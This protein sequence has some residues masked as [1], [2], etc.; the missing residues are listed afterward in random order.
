MLSILLESL[1]WLGFGIIVVAYGLSSASIIKN[2][3]VLYQVLNLVGALFLSIISFY[4]HA[5]QPA[6]LNVVWFFVALSSLIMILKK[7]KVLK[8]Q[9]ALLQRE[10]L[11]R[12]TVS[13]N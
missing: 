10:E 1:G 11:L 4:R 5:L 8:A 9:K 6:V 3:T 7:N 13:V 2:D 12:E